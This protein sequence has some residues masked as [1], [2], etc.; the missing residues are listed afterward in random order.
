MV[1]AAIEIFLIGFALTF[2]PISDSFASDKSNMTSKRLAPCPH[3]PNCVSSQ[4]VKSD[5]YIQPIR[6]EG[7]ADLAFSKLE[8]II[9]ALPGAR[10]IVREDAYIHTE[11]QSKWLKFIDDVE[12]ILDS[13]NNIIHIRSASRI[14]Y[15][16]FGANR[17]RVEFI[18]SQYIED[19]SGEGG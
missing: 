13:E 18:R 16:D 12:S 1:C 11:F 3:S 17:K 9:L 14:G 5:Q 2:S 7:P 10:I 19:L 8:R 6:F 4:A 15:S